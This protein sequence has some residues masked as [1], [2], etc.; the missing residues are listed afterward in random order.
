M[1]K[2][3]RDKESARLKAFNN[4]PP[5]KVM[6]SIYTYI[7]FYMPQATQFT[8]DWVAQCNDSLMGKYQRRDKQKPLE[9]KYIQSCKDHLHTQ[10]TFTEEHYD[11]LDDKLVKSV[12]E[13]MT[14]D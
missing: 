2:K 10:Q 14:D 12:F 9:R 1:K 5:E 7:I 3:Q 6:L 8:E 11:K 4:S 13:S